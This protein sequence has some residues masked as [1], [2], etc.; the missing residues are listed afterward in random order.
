MKIVSGSFQTLIQ[1]CEMNRDMMDWSYS[2]YM[3]LYKNKSNKNKKKILLTSLY[4]D[5]SYMYVTSTAGRTAQPTLI[6]NRHWWE[7][8]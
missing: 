8:A 2:M 5:V 3:Y 4:I 1:D 7:T 6:L